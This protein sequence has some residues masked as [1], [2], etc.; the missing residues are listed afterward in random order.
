M[1][2]TVSRIYQA[3]ENANAATAA[4]EQA[5]FD[6]GAIH[7]VEP[8]VVGSAAASDEQIATRV[9]QSGVA[10][11]H[12]DLFADAIK[13]GGTLVSIQA[14]FGTAATA[15]RILEQHGPTSTGLPEQG[16][17][18][19]APE[20]AAPFSSACGMT[21]LVHNPTPLSSLLGLAVLS[22]SAPR[23]RSDD[24]LVDNPA[25]FSKIVAAPVLTDRPAMLSSSTGMPV[26]LD[27]SAP[28]S[29]LLHVPILTKS[30]A[31]TGQV[32][33]DKPSPFSSALGLKLL[34]ND[35]APLSR[36]LGWRVLS[37]DPQP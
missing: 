18:D 32:L 30:S 2:Q 20:P 14:Q 5:G 22:T 8:N 34:S 27:K 3:R 37:D 11:S 13:A 6:P 23:R 16:H 7:V 17:H 25:P 36:L 9:R 26:L 24:E 31:T 33:P 10:A 28:L 1:T 15:T 29:A 35:P 4:L 21:V 19:A 12:A